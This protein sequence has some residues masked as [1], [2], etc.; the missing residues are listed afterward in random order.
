MN[1]LSKYLKSSI[2]FK[3]AMALMLLIITLMVIVTY[4]FA[5]RELNLRTE[6]VELRMEQLARNIAAIRTV[7]TEDWEIYQTYIDNQLRLYEDIVYIVIFDENDI[8]KIHALNKDW[9]DLGDRTN[10]SKLE[11]ANIV[12]QLDQRQI[13]AESQKDLQS[14]SVNIMIGERN[15]GTVRVGFSLVKIN[16]EIRGNLLLNLRLG[17]IFTLVAMILAYFISYRIVTPLKRLTSAMLRISQGHFDEQLTIR[18]NDELG[19]LAKTFNSMTKGLSEKQLI[20]KF[21]S[22]LGFTVELSK[23]VDLIARRI[24][25]GLNAKHGY[26]FIIDTQLANTFRLFSCYP[27]CEIGEMNIQRNPD[28]CKIFLDHKLPLSINRFTSMPDFSSALSRLNLGERSLICPIIIKEKVTGILLLDEKKDG[29]SYSDEETGFLTTLINQAGFALESAMLYLELTEQERLKHELEIAKK[30]Q[31]SLLP[32]DNPRFKGLDIDGICKPATE[33]GGDYY[34][35]FIIDDHK[36]AIAIAD[37]TGKGTSAAFYMAVVKGIMISLASIIRSPRDVLIEVNKRLYG[38]MDR[39]VFITMIYGVVDIRSRQLT[40]ARAGHNSLLYKRSNLTA[41]DELVPD[42]IGLGLESGAVF[43]QAL[44]EHK[45]NLRKGDLVVFYTDGITEAMNGHRKEFT[46][47]KLIS[48]IA[49]TENPTAGQLRHA[50]LNE[51]EKFVAGAPQHDD[52]TLVTI[53]IV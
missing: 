51:L 19:D 29:V 21:N 20:E 53:R 38:N 42:G 26:L 1:F 40:F 4:I 47:Q 31:Q 3:M 24:S 27:G 30:I 15:L 50:I 35:F 36:I 25:E 22:E 13:A 49:Q 5:I 17:I 8:L 43:D 2:G 12:I 37:V 6:Q 18:S 14:R 33:V 52:I 46:E 16:D 41:V 45:M 10:I 28:S 7:E 48:I 44:V 11:E 9:I 34:D 23:I 39:R 32:Q